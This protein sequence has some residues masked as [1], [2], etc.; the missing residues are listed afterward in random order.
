MYDINGKVAIVTGGANGLGKATVEAILAKGGIPVI[1]DWNEELG[2][3]TAEEFG[4]PFFK[5]D[6]SNEDQV[7]NLVEETVKLYGHLDIMVNNAGIADGKLLHE[8]TTEEYRHVLG[9]N[10]DGVYFG[11]KYAVQQ[12]LKQGTPGAI[13][14]VSSMM[15][16]ISAP[17]APFY[18]L[19][20]TSIRGI[21]KSMAAAYA[22]QGI[23][24]NSIH[25][26]NV[27][28]GL[29]CKEYLGEEIISMME[30]AVPI[31]RLGCADEIAHAIIFMIENTFLVGSEIVVDGGYVIQ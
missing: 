2:K 28:S 29:C 7:K 11:C 12:L 13:V 10:Q 17:Q 6:V 30:S 23:R 16:I 15:G 25:P 14:N 19:S 22:R 26:G 24:V 20:K 27:T 3:K 21:T 1:A 9:V 5:V 31:G 8:T 4:V 18:T